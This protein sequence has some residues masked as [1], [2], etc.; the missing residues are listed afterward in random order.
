MTD[1]S[2]RKE[3]FK[4]CRSATFSIDGYSFTIGQ[5]GYKSQLLL[6]AFESE[7]YIKVLFGSVA[8]ICQGQEKAIGGDLG[9]FAS[10][11]GVAQDLG[12]MGW[13]YYYQNSV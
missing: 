5:C 10:S 4:K 3:G 12:G 8:E 1:A 9:H 7:G 11:N 6:G 2:N 13:T